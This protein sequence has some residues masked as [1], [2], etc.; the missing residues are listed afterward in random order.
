MKSNSCG[1]RSVQVEKEKGSTLTLER[2]RKLGVRTSRTT[3]V[4]NVLRRTSKQNTV[5]VLVRVHLLQAEKRAGRVE[6]NSTKERP[7]SERREY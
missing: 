6:H 5:Q 4:L 7:T 1:T 2:R 3:R